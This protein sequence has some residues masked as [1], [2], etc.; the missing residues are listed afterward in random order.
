MTWGNVQKERPRTGSA[1]LIT[2][3]FVAI[4]AS[5]AVALAVASDANLTISR[6][7]LDIGQA[8][9]LVE[10]GLCMVQREMTTA[11][12]TG[13]N[14]AALHASLAEHF[15]TSWAN[16]LTANSDRI[17]A[18]EDGVSFP[19][20]STPGPGDQ[21]GTIV[22]GMVADGGVGNAPTVT[23]TSTG[24]FG[25]AT[26][27]A[28]Y[29]FHVRSGCKF[30]SDY[31]VASMAP[32]SMRGNATI[33]GANNASEGSI[34]SAHDSTA[35]IDLRGNAHVTGDAAVSAEGADI[36]TRGNGTIDGNEL[37]GAASQEWPDVDTSLFEQYVETTYSGPST[38]KN[39]TLSN[40]RIP[41][42]TN[43]VFKGN[44]NLYGVIYIESPNTVTFND[45]ANICGVVVCEEPAVENYSTNTITFKKN[46][47]AAG[48][49]YLPDDPQ[50]DGLRDLTGT[51]LLAPG[52]ETI[53]KK[54]FS[55]INGYIAAGKMTFQGNASG[56]VRGGLLALDDAG[57]S[58]AGNAHVTIDKDNAAQHPAGFSQS[59]SLICVSGSYRE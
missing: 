31:G 55:T 40:I 17:E 24:R 59:Y 46:L 6:N 37:I 4:F 53:F 57:L 29:D 26:R 7:R 9:S 38:I 34:Y 48:V 50:Y 45:N 47:T 30:F 56:T 25:E 20:I 21:A 13:A 41:P 39:A 42:N 49:E 33:D 27:T 54:N 16:V 19:A 10:T 14:A 5:M 22:L 23:L 35:A 11:E 18:S 52:F 58:M 44:T 8:Q 2:L 12:V 51:F 15:Q 32:I 43:P 3:I 1:L 28:Y 36:S